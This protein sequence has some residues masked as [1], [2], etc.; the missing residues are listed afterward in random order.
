MTSKRHIFNIALL[1]AGT[2]I[3]CNTECMIK[4][5]EKKETAEK[6]DTK[7]SSTL[8]AQ[9]PLDP[10]KIKIWRDMSLWGEKIPEWLE[11]EMRENEQ[12]LCPCP[13]KLAQKICCLPSYCTSTVAGDKCLAKTECCLLYSCL[14]VSS[15]VCCIPLCCC[16]P[17]PN[18]EEELAKF[19]PKKKTK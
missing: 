9:A 12:R 16:P 17:A 14:A 10:E 8:L 15:I 4:Q 7:N 1:I 11:K 13:V 18:F 6:I 19:D 5:S 3:S 2:F